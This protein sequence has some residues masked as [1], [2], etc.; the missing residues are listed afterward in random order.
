MLPTKFRFM[1]PSGFREEYSLEIDQPEFF[2]LPMA[3][4]LVNGSGR[5][6]HLY[7][8]PSIDDFCQAL[9]HLTKRFQRRFLEI[10]QPEK[11]NYCLWR[12]CLLTDREEMNTLL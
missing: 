12:P 11:K 6:E 8:E 2:L 10:D 7:R 5:N 9:V 1:W 4:M 3:A